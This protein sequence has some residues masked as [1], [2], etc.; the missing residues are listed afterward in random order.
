MAINVQVG[1]VTGLWR[2]PVKSMRGER[3]DAAPVTERGL[4]GDRAYA[5]M[6]NDT[7][8]VVSAKSVKRFPDLLQCQARFVESPWAGEDLPPVEI[9]LPDGTTVRSDA[10]DVS[11]MLSTF[12]QRDVTLARAAPNGGSFQRLTSRLLAAE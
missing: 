11:G 6:D 8:K 1:S 7:G 10:S 3:L 9:T 12:F 4:V 2:F 5:L